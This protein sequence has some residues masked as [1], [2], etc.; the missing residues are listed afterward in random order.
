M[1]D[2]QNQSGLMFTC[3][4]LAGLRNI[5]FC[6]IKELKA[7]CRAEETKKRRNEHET[8]KRRNDGMKKRR[9]EYENDGKEQNEETTG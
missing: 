7:F 1:N 4:V 5:T 9:N 2:K 6:R 3:G 8:K